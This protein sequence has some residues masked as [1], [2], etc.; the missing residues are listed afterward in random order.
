MTAE[1]AIGTAA[2]L[3]ALLGCSWLSWLC[4]RAYLRGRGR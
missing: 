4:A 3:V 2:G 1:G